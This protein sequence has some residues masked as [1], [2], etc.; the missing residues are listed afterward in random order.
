MSTVNNLPSD[1]NELQALI[2][3]NMA[4]FKSHEK[5]AGSK[6]ALLQ[7]SQTLLDVLDE[8]SA[9]PS[10]SSSSKVVRPDF[11]AGSASNS[12]ANGAPSNAQMQQELGKLMLVLAT[13]QN[14]IAESGNT[15]SQLNAKIGAS[16]IKEMEA[17]VKKAD[18][19][20]KKVIE[21]EKQSS[22]WSIFEKVAEGIAGVA[23][24]AI[25]VLCGQPELAIIVMTF[26]VLAVS[27]GMDKMTQALADVYSQSL[28]STFGCSKE[29]ADAIAKPLA[30]V[31]IVIA[32]IIVTAT[33]CG[34]TAGA[35]AETTAE[36][37]ASTAEETTDTTLATVS[38]SALQEESTM[39]RI[40]S[41]FGKVGNYL[42]ENNPFNKLPKWA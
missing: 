13:L 38:E 8:L 3:A 37:I 12:A 5:H 9:S 23:I 20:V 26:T 24:S 41:F 10:K 6:A 36:T 31:T 30:D 19:Q 35:A 40:T 33:T 16:L 25:A 1:S 11:K 21:E 39:Q 17:M 29:E 34:V 15:N 22:F 7:L 32:S 18:D 2:A 27:G 28:M 14:K 4:Q 42:K